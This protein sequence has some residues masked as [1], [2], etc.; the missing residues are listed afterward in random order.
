MNTI[1][2]GWLCP[3][4]GSAHSPDVLTCPV[5]AAPMPFV[6]VPSWPPFVSPQPF[7]PPY[8]PWPPFTW[9]TIKCKADPNLWIMI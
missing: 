5:T 8:P 1:R 7:T 2:E 6:P 4:C 3:K 9:G